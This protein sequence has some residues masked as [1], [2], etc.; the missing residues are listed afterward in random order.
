MMVFSGSAPRKS[1]PAESRRAPP[2]HRGAARYWAADLKGG[3]RRAG[4]P[5]NLETVHKR[6]D[7]P[8]A[9]RVRAGQR[10][11]GKNRKDVLKTRVRVTDQIKDLTHSIMNLSFAGKQRLFRGV[12]NGPV[13][14]GFSTPIPHCDLETEDA[15]AE[16]LK[17]TRVPC[18]ALSKF[19]RRKAVCE[20]VSRAVQYYE[21][22]IDGA[23]IWRRL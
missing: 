9:H 20:T 6:G 22:A 4:I 3:G 10:T 19:G 14:V 21:T 23:C 1:P 11:D 8:R 7:I 18:R 5:R 17:H 15:L 13:V 12:L 2:W 16:I